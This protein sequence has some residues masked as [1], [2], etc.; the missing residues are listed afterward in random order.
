MNA[1]VASDKFRRV[2]DQVWRDREALLTRRGCLT[3]EAALMRAVYWRL[4]NAWG[5]VSACGDGSHA[6]Q[7]LFIYQ[8]LVNILLTQ[9]VGPHYD[10]SALLN[11]LVRRYREEAVHYAE[12]VRAPEARE[13]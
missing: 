11:E 5:G 1:A 10:G 12:S 8:R 2:C 4:C 13:G 9:N 3:G 6:G 7:T